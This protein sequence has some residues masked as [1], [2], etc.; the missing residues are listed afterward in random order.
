MRSV[1]NSAKAVIIRDGRVLLTVNKDE[2]GA[3]YLLP[4]GGQVA[5]ETLPEALQRECREEIGVDVI[6]GELRYVREYISRNHE[7]AASD[8]DA[9]QMEYMFTCRLPDGAEPAQG[10]TPD[11]WQAGI[12]WVPLE[13]LTATRLYPA[14]LR[15]LLAAGCADGPVYLGDVN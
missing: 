11:T 9:H 2:D 8:G 7:F 3:F 1:R 12:E 13:R 5:G 15:P 6:V 10:H 14:V 4:G